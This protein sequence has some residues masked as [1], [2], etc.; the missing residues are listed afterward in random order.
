MHLAKQMDLIP[1]E[2]DGKDIKVMA[3]TKDM[4]KQMEQETKPLAD[5][6]NHYQM[7]RKKGTKT[8]S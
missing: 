8:V 7:V 3:P 4:L 5:L 2:T 6:R 1:E